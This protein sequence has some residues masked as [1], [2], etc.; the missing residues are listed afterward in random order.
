M[1]AVPQEFSGWIEIKGISPTGFMYCLRKPKLT[2][3]ATSG[4]FA[5]GTSADSTHSSKSYVASASLDIET[6]A[7]KININYLAVDYGGDR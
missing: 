4:Y 1:L 5:N 7:E 3:T 6:T 2:A